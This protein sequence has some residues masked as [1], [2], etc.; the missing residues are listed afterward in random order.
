MFE[1]E[2]YYKDGDEAK[3]N[4]NESSFKEEVLWVQKYY[5]HL[6]LGVIRL[7]VPNN[8][9]CNSLKKPM[10]TTKPF[11]FSYQRKLPESKSDKKPQH[12]TD[13][14]INL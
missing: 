9:F 8:E 12:N 5:S 11:W 6:K 10:G 13:A 4:V 1:E 14:W 3:K 2:R 7:L